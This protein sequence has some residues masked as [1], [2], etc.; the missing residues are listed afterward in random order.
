MDSRVMVCVMDDLDS[1]KSEGKKKY[2]ED[3]F[4]GCSSEAIP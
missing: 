2:M 1:S 3:I 4:G